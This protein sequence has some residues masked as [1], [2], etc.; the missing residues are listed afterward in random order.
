MDTAWKKILDLYF[1]QHDGRQIIYHQIA[2]FNHFMDFDVV[3]TILRSC[4]IRVVGSPDLTL[5]GTTRAAAGTA[6]TAIRVT[7]EDATG[8]PSGTAPATALPGGKAPGGGPPREVEVIVKFQNVSIRKPT[9]FENNGALTPMYPNDARL[10]NFTYAAPVYLDIDVTTTMTDPG[11]GTK[12]TRTRTLTKVLAGKIPVMVGSKYCLLSE[13][14]EKH[15]RELGECSADPFGYFIIQGGERV[16]LSQERMA[17]NRMFVFRNNKA[18]HKEAEIIECKSIGPD[19]E[20][21]PKNIAVKIIYN[22]KLATGPEHIRMTLPRIKAEIPLFIMFRALGIESD[23]GILELIMGAAHSDYDMIFQECIYESAEIRT[24]QAAQ[25]YLQK[26]LGSGGGIR[27]QLSAST[28]AS[29]KAPKDKLIG[30]ILAE[31][32]LPH[33][34]GSEMMYEKAC[35]LAAMTKK[36]L[37]VYHNKLPCDDRDAYPNK[38]VEH[39][40]NLLGNLFRFYFGTKVIKDMKSTIVKEIHNGAWKASGKFE[41]IINT[42]NVYK[43]LKTTIVD[44]GMKSSLATGNFASGKM[45][46]KS[47]ISQVMNRLTFLSGIS[48]LRRLSTPIEKTGKLIPPRKL[49]NSQFGYICPAETPEGHSVGVVKNLA[50]TANVTLPSSPNPV[51][52]VLYDEL[53]MKHLNETTALERRD[54]LRVFV[55]GAWIGTLGTS[56]QAASAVKSLVIA[57]RSGRMHIFTSIVYKSST[58]EV[59][60]NTEGG[61]IVRPLFV[62]ATI[63]EILSTGLTHPWTFCTSW[64]DLMRW[65]SPAGNHLLEFVDAG[66]SEGLY[67][68]KT[69]GTLAKDHTHLEIHPS[70]IIGTMGSN[71]PFPDHNQ[72]PRN[73]YQ[74]AMGKQAMGVYALNFTERL[75]TMSNLLC[76]TARPLVSPYMSKYYRAQDMPSGYNIIVAIMTYG[77]YNQEDSVMINRAAL[78]RGLFRSIFYRTYKDE[79]KKNQ[80]SGEE[81]RFCKPDVSLTKHMKLANYEKLAADGIVPENVFVDN[82]DIL[83]GKVVPIRLRAVE[84]AMAAGV[85]HSSLASMSAAAAAAAVEAVGGKRYRD[86]S[87]LL[88]NNETGYVDKIYRG[89]NGE[90]FSFVKIRVR[91]ERIPTIGDKFCCYDPQTEIL[92]SS[93]WKFFPD[94][95]TE[96]KVATLQEVG[97]QKVLEYQ[98]P[99]EVMNYDFDGDMYRVESGQV[100]LMVTK[101][102][103]MYVSHTRTNP[104]TYKIQLAEEI[105]GSRRY[106]KKDVDNYVPPVMTNSKNLCYLNKETGAT[107]T[108]PQ[109]F[110]IDDFKMPINDWLVFFGIWIAEGWVHGTTLIV[111]AFKERV[112]KALDDI[113]ERNNIKITASRDPRFERTMPAGE[114]TSYHIVHTMI[115]QYLKP[116]SVGA[117]NKSLPEW[118]WYLTTEQSRQLINGMMLGDGHD[119]KNGT[120][121]YDTSSKQLKDDFQKLCLHA[122]YSA[123]YFVK[124][125]AGH[126]TTIKDP[127]R[128]GETITTTTEAYRLTI[129]ESQNQPLVNKNIKPDGTDRLDSYVK[130]TGKVY[131]CRVNGPGVVYVRRN[132]VPVWCGQSRHGQKGTCGLILEPEDMPQT[133]S[134]IVPDIIINPHCIPSRMTIAHLMETLMGRIGCEIGAVGD[135]SP[136]TDVSVDGLARTLRDDLG[137]EPYTNEVMY[138]GTTGKQM[139]TSIFM[140][141][142]FYQRLKHMV[143]DKIHCLTPDHDVLTTKGW[144]P[145]AE[146]TLDDKVATLQQGKVCYEHPIKT[147]DYDYVGKMYQVQ[148]QQIDLKVTPNHRMWVGTPY[149]RQKVWNWGFHEAKDIQGKHVKYQKD[150][151]WEKEP[152]QFVLPAQGKHEA[153]ALD[154]DA[155][156]TFFGIWIAEGWASLKSQIGLA[157]N[158]ERVKSALSVIMDKLEIP[159]RY[160]PLAEKVTI[161]HS[162]LRQYLIPLSPGAKNKYLPDWVWELDAE[163][164]KKLIAGLLLG[165]GHTT[166]S[167]SIIYSTSS[168]KLADDV[169]RLCLHAGWSANIRLHT[170]AGSPYTIGD[171]SGFTTADLLSVRIIR[172]KNRPAVNHGHVYEQQIQSERMMDY[173]GKVHCLE[174]PGNVFYVRRSGMPVWTGNSR[175][176][177]PLVML[178]RQPAEGRARDGGLRFGEMERDCGTEEMQVLT[179]KGFLFLHDFE[180]MHDDKSL[181][182][183]SYDTI[184]KELIYESMNELIVK[185]A[186]EQTMIEFAY[187]QDSSIVMTPRHDMYVKQSTDYQ[188]VKA[189]SLLSVDSNGHVNMLCYTP[190]TMKLYE[191]TL[192]Q[193]HDIKEITYTGRTWCVNVP[194]GFI[195]ARRAETKDDVV[196][197]ASVP[198]IMGNCIVAHGASEFLKEIMMEKADNFQ[199]FICKSCGLLGQVNPKAGIF[200]CTSCEGVTDFAQ[201]RVPYAY[202]LFLQELESMSICSRIL[203]ESRLRMI[204]NSASLM[205]EPTATKSV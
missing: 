190:S 101:N 85:S 104:K 64:N 174:V 147:F 175:S 76:Y 20:G 151:L 10:R 186:K 121:R 41:N 32:F 46:T 100:D 187:E 177:G 198:V 199:C 45:G 179:N 173:D 48:H 38:K 178:T 176:S 118:A 152:Y 22:P 21:V 126:T 63:R 117:V 184:T 55:N 2:S 79:E 120:R 82:D 163:Q 62:G 50:S 26:H 61:R 1:A 5:T 29:Y 136:F 123:N 191:T 158:K 182:V 36:V 114:N 162:Q 138:C 90:G 134:G 107:M 156:L 195:V 130:Y 11:K 128:A 205:P 193:A 110:M 30:E 119:M 139:K 93:G 144:K 165:D 24:K 153:R 188:K 172:A 201:I 125:E 154:M 58:N 39:P 57:K 60:M 189:A 53:K 95:T 23:K 131:C 200:K 133:S 111:S 94:L 180:A 99:Q 97:D 108:E 169:Q 37:D 192:N 86:S 80:A 84:G 15:P 72:S 185:P 142:I 203:P 197:K 88:R 137:L 40:G 140:G 150:G 69:L 113:C 70:V 44:V 56:A 42:T 28:L 65:V 47:G 124:C 109:S 146:V 34:G 106:Y 194:H 105:Y 160:E 16:I 25:D 168:R 204:S 67:I 17:E 33:I 202:K 51:L 52:R 149:G 102:H 183:A 19:N 161:S 75:D 98:A 6:G 83:I 73:S 115:R 8:T 127:R 122:G 27:E 35:F 81:E 116:L 167:G 141:P 96:D 7:V 68:S 43:I 92:T 77:G 59:W 91:S 129:V 171:H 112:R 12:E 9:I 49:H 13:S 4:P 89:R 157:V 196:I 31:E 155:W 148:T 71:I 135:G 159:Y 66:E 87:K 14:P 54:L 132:G 103:R 78:D 18:K 143:D 3:D 74:A 166:A 170:L 181:L 145:I 164:S